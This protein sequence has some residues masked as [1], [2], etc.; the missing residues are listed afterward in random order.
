MKLLCRSSSERRLGRIRVR[1]GVDAVIT[2]LTSK[3]ADRVAGIDESGTTSNLDDINH[4]I[5][6]RNAPESERHLY[7]LDDVGHE[8][9]KSSLAR[10]AYQQ[11]ND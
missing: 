1:I 4:S 3:I 9:S 2:L 8:I 7:N 10:K 5:R 6:R 11:I